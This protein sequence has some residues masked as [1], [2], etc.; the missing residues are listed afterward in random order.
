MNR[1][2]DFTN[3]LV[4]VFFALLRKLKVELNCDMIMLT[5]RS[6]ETFSDRVHFPSAAFLSSALEDYE[7]LPLSSLHT[8]SVRRRDV[9]TETHV[10]KMVSFNALQR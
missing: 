8:H 2:V 10:E 1:R 7:I 5:S 4:K 9:Q 6:Q 3:I